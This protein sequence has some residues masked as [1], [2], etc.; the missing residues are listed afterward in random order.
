MNVV[1]MELIYTYNMLAA[2][3]AAEVKAN[4]SRTEH[5]FNLRN[6]AIATEQE[7]IAAGFALDAGI[8]FGQSDNVWD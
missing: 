6:A 5:G 1:M 3:V 7:I 2:L 4:G 8:I